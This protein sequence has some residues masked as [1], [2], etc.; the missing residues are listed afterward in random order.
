MKHWD[1]YD[2]GGSIESELEA[3][4]VSKLDAFEQM[5]YSDLI[6][7]STKA[8]ALKILINN[9]EGDFSQLSPNLN[10]IAEMYYPEE[11]NYFMDDNYADGGGVGEIFILNKIFYYL[12]G[13]NKFPIQVEE[14]LNVILNKFMTIDEIS[15]YIKRELKINQRLV[16]YTHSIRKESVSS[17][18][19]MKGFQIIK[20]SDGTDKVIYSKSDIIYA[21]IDMI[22]DYNKE[23]MPVIGY[24]EWKVIYVG[25]GRYSY[26]VREIFVYAKNREEAIENARKETLDIKS[27]KSV[28]KALGYGQN[29]RIKKTYANG[30]GVGG[31]KTDFND[32][33]NEGLRKAL[34]SFREDFNNFL[35]NYLQVGK[36]NYIL[37]NIDNVMVI[38]RDKSLGD[39]SDVE[40]VAINKWIQPYFD[41]TQKP[42]IAEYLNGYKIDGN[43][44]IIDIKDSQMYANGGGIER[45][46][47]FEDYE[48]IP[49]NIQEI[50]DEYSQD[51][52]DGN[53]DGL[54]KA[55]EEVESQGYTFEYY[56][57]GQAYGLRPIGVPLNELKGYEYEIEI[58][59]P[60]E[61]SSRRFG[62]VFGYL[63]KDKKYVYVASEEDAFA[64]TGGWSVWN[65]YKDKKNLEGI[66]N[67]VGLEEIKPHNSYD[68]E[69]EALDAAYRFSLEDE[70][71]AGGGA[72]ANG[73]GVSDLKA[74][75]IYSKKM[76]YYYKGEITEYTV[77]PIVIDIID[78]KW[79]YYQNY[80]LANT[81]EKMPLFI[82]KQ[83]I[84]EGLIKPYNIKD[85]HGE[86]TRS[87]NTF[88]HILYLRNLAD[89][90]PF[91]KEE[92]SKIKERF[93]DERHR[94][95][96]KRARRGFEGEYIDDIT[97][98][99]SRNAWT[100]SRFISIHKLSN[101]PK[102]NEP[103]NKVIVTEDNR[104][105]NSHFIY[106]NVDDFIRN[107]ET[108]MEMGGSISDLQ[109]TSN[110]LIKSKES[111]LKEKLFDGRI[112]EVDLKNIIGFEPNYPTQIV[113]TIKL[114]KCFLL[115][116]YKIK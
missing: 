75:N 79:I 35:S 32:L 43:R 70:S 69:Q 54:A 53:Y 60:Q 77:Q 22:R 92:F 93:N 94:V 37:S 113:G 98:E 44:I 24:N 90:L 64:P 63:T 27:I 112:S 9:V 16:Y 11:D 12:Y 105:R 82:F 25:E 96:L 7:H 108:N 48:N 72:Y 88:L 114:E 39:F 86:V 91:T 15:D 111:K 38:F 31:V 10:D 80:Q 97:V 8:E 21:V 59:E 17:S 102:L 33:N 58:P 103:F 4:D 104:D 73:G 78:D 20:N 26:E 40:N 2:I 71:Y 85:L 89:Y 14:N 62:K 6:K 116:Y 28:E 42:L 19:M 65:G 115:P 23:E 45:I 84:E 34:I 76:P 101:T 46:D 13:E 87:L 5:Q 106:D 51:F 29:L 81:A 61:F 1:K 3:F 56:L 67:V 30:G 18:S 50:L 41:I 100:N 95:E 55:L 68:T 107:H 36:E 52:E 83:K 74:G 49:T 99:I 109:F 110:T 66:Y 57:D 47:L